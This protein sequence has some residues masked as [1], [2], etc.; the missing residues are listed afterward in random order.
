MNIFKGL[1]SW[2]KAENRAFLIAQVLTKHRAWFPAHN[3]GRHAPP[4][5]LAAWERQ[6]Q[7]VTVEELILLIADNHA[8]NRLLRKNWPPGDGEGSPG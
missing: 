5:A 7:P 6:L 4:E 1:F 2:K 3:R 8:R